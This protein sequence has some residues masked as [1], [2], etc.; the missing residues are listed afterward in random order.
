MART[1]FM[2]YNIAS[3]G[4][5]LVKWRPRVKLIVFDISHEVVFSNFSVKNDGNLNFF[6][7]F[8][9]K[10][11]IFYEFMTCTHTSHTFHAI[12]HLRLFICLFLNI[13]KLC[14]DIFI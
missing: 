6:F 12:K 8:F 1:H 11:N 9:I 10:G 7:F 5:E 2:R 13:K 14:Y 4:N 3:E